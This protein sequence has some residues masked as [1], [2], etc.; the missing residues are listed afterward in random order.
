MR[1]TTIG[2]DLAKSIFQVHGVDA[3]GAVVVR[4]TLRRGQVLSFFSKLEPCLVGIEACGTSHHW[5]RSIARL[6]HEVRLMA[7]AYVK[8]YV[9]RPTP[10]MLRRSARR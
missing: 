1:I 10:T 2:L 6:G 3:D 4:K 8:P 9:K 7:A 5:A